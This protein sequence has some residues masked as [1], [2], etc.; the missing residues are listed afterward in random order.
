MKEGLLDT[1]ERQRKPIVPTGFVLPLVLILV[2]AIAVLSMGYL[3]RSDLE[4]AYGRNMVLRTQMDSLAQ[5]GLEHAK[6]L[7]LNPQDVPS[8]YWT[9]SLRQQ[10][11]PESDDYYDVNVVRLSECNY[12]I[13][14]TAYRLQGD[15]LIGYAALKAEL[16]LDPCIAYWQRGNTVIPPQAS[17]RGDVY[18]GGKLAVQGTIDGD[19]FAAV[20]IDVAGGVSGQRHPFVVSA[21]VVSPELVP[22][23]FASHYYI[24]RRAYVVDVIG[25]DVLCDVQLQPTAQNPAGIHYC[26]GPLRLKKRVEIHGMLVVEQDL[27]LEDECDVVVKAVKNFPALVAGHDIKMRGV[28]QHLRID[29]LAQIGHCIDMGNGAG[30]TIQ[31][32]GALCTLAEGV[33]QTTGCELAVKAGPDKAAIQVWP[34]PGVSKRWSPTAGAFFKS[35]TRP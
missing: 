11:I 13:V 5:S 16:R 27:V 1:R 15:E 6:G 21:P 18:C 25:T 19:V 12:Q 2:M 26:S 28:G 22:A 34:A 23:D 20:T 30:N 10:I 29:G 35:I 31:I 8:E 24:E 33:K 9:G 3:W 7:I 4:L 17:I 14:S 32:T